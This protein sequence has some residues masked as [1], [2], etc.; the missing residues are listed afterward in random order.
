MPD[1][2]EALHDLGTAGRER[3]D[4]PV[5]RIGRD[6]N[7]ARRKQVTDRGGGFHCFATQMPAAARGEIAPLFPGGASPQRSAQA[8][9]DQAGGG[10]LRT[11]SSAICSNVSHSTPVCPEMCSMTRSSM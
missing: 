3:H 11:K 6:H 10:L 1:F 8:A 5:I 7:A 2:P 9:H 4:E